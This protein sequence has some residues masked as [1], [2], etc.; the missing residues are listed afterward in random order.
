MN[1]RIWLN[2]FMLALVVVLAGLIFLSDEESVPSL[3]GL[4]K[5]SIVSMDIRHR[6]RHIVLQRREDGWQMT[7]PVDIAAND[8]RVD[9]VLNLI[10]ATPAASYDIDTIELADFQLDAPR[11]SIRFSDGVSEMLLEF[12]AANPINRM[13][14]VRVADRM[15]LIED[16][17]YPLV[18]SQT[19]TLIS[20][21]LLP[22]SAQIIELE[23]PGFRFSKEGST[24]QVTP[25]DAGFDSD[26]IAGLM[27]DW[28]RAQSFGVHDLVDRDSLGDVRIRY[29][30]A[31]TE[32]TRALSV[33]DID[34]WL[35]LAVPAQGI[36]YHLD[37]SLYDRLFNPTTAAERE[38]LDAEEQVMT[39]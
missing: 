25:E 33:T 38:V 18:S 29:R 14:Y 9:S 35:I 6:D 13:R 23:I 24:W 21:Q 11:T 1:Q 28:V 16:H 2:L 22:D 27:D 19:G 17:L 30:L 36:E 15:F 26:V 34:P 4:D 8:F 12:G 32:T 10:D 37:I 3:T 20:Q 5:Q 31:G 39:Q 7:R